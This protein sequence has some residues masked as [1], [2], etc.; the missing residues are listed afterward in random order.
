[1]S[2]PQVTFEKTMRSRWRVHVNGIFYGIMHKTSMGYAVIAAGTGA[3]VAGWRSTQ[4]EIA[5]EI[6]NIHQ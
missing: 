3:M 1:M 4:R 6:R 2:L 5:D